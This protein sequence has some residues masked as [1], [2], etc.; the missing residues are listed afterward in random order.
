MNELDKN[1]ADMTNAAVQ[2]SEGMKTMVNCMRTQYTLIAQLTAQLPEGTV[3]PLVPATVAAFTPI[4]DVAIIAPPITGGTTDCTELDD[5]N[6]PW[7]ARIH[8]NTKGKVASKLVKKGKAWRLAKGVDKDL[9]EVVKAENKVD[10]SIDV[11][12][13]PIAVE[14]APGIA[15]TPSVTLPPTV[16]ATPSMTLPPTV[17]A[18]PVDEH[19]EM[20]TNCILVIKNLIDNFGL[21][22]DDCKEIVTTATGAAQNG[23]E[24]T[25]GALTYDQY[26]IILS[27]FEAL[28]T[29]YTQLVALVEQVFTYATPAHKVMVDGQ[30]VTLLAPFNT[31]SVDGIY[32]GDLD[33]AHA[34][35]AP[36][37]KQWS[38]WSTGK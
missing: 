35:A 30:V 29:K 24:V 36:W 12:D 4:A 18:E 2:V 31:E 28:L 10:V 9:V 32:Y 25:F 7:D 15:T 38:D 34:A 5:E 19:A 20:R 27:T 23:D 37:V 13:A 1:L 26:P 21:D 3:L 22:W 6:Q 16:A 14:E 11:V 33:A 17:A 8:A